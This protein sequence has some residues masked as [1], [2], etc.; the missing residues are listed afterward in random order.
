MADAAEAE[1][2]FGLTLSDLAAFRDL[3]G[4]VL[5]VAHNAYRNRPPAELLAMV[6]PGGVVIDVK[7]MLNAADMPDGM[8]YWSL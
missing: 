2:E 1:H 6:K 5:A 3:D 7:S 8:A 4:L